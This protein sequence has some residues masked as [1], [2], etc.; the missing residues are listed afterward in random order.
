MLMFIKEN[1]KLVIIAVVIIL[2]I[3]SLIAIVRDRI[4]FDTTEAEEFS[5]YKVCKINVDEQPELASK[6]QVM[7]IPALF[8]VENGAVINKSIGAIPKSQIL[9][10]L[11]WAYSRGI[12]PAAV[13]NII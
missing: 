13:V 8:V 6:F 3:I 11:N 5:E 1:K 7:S 4:I 12:F 9:D 10:L 2:I